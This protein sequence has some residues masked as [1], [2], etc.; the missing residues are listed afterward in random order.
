MGYWILFFDGVSLEALS[1]WISKLLQRLKT[2][3]TEFSR[4]GRYCIC[5]KITRKPDGFSFEYF[6]DTHSKAALNCLKHNGELK[7]FHKA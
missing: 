6:K 7:L 5:R 1:L 4:F 3:S 2:F